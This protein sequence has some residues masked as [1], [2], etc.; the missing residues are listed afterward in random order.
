MRGK[1]RERVGYGLLFLF[2]SLVLQVLSLKGGSGDGKI[3]EWPQ[4]CLGGS[5][6][7]LG[8]MGTYSIL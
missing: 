3:A 6:L 8:D 5:T 7:A 1:G 2:Q 4:G